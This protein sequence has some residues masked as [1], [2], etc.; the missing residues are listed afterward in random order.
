MKPDKTTL[1]VCALCMAAI[2]VALYTRT[3][4]YPIAPSRLDPVVRETDKYK[5]TAGRIVIH[6]HERHPYYVSHGKGVGGIIGDRINFVFEQAG[7]PLAWQKTPAQR[8]LGIIK[9]NSGREAAAGWFKTPE[10]ET[11]AKFSHPIY[12]DRA[13]I[14]LARADQE[15][16]QSG[17]TL[18]DTL[19][20]PNLRLLRKNGYSYGDFID[21]LLDRFQ[22]NQTV[23]FGD[24]VGMLK[25]IHTRRVDYLF[26]AREEAD[27]LLTRAGLPASDFKKITFTDMPE[28]N[29]RYILFSRQVED[30]TIDRLDRV[31]RQYGIDEPDDGSAT[32]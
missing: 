25:M 12:Q 18:A 27:D 15:M 1:V 6:Y 28:G 8:Q 20:N 26:I 3:A 21:R 5:Y 23:T 11:F 4:I 17:G 31:L 7:V 13:T 24:N 22:P 30:S 32:K 16:I 2:T 14:A 29:R 19:A 10:R 9:K